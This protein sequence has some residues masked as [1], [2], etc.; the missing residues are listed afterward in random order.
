M[1]K[2]LIVFLS[3]ATAAGVRA[4]TGQA[5]LGPGP[6][7]T[8]EHLV[9]D[10]GTIAEGAD[11]RCEFNYQNTGDQPLILTNCQSS[12]GCLV[13]SCDREPLAPGKSAT[14]KARYDTKRV[15]RFTKSITVT[16]NAVNTPVVVLSIKGQVLPDSSL[17]VPPS[18][19]DA[20]R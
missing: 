19:P 4:Q 12:C 14:L 20:P 1:N 2:P 16:S 17:M 11:G 7:I 9:Y 6:M 3:I 18:V 15:G 13:A 10:Y 5:E 8:F